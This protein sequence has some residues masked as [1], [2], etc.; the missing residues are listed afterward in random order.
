MLVSNLADSLSGAGRTVVDTIGEDPVVTPRIN[1]SSGPDQCSSA[2]IGEDVAIVYADDR[3]ARKRMH[4]I[5]AVVVYLRIGN[6]NHRYAA[7][8]F[9]KHSIVSVA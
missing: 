4:T 8:T 1:L 5:R 9:S 3:A 7:N 6:V 2:R